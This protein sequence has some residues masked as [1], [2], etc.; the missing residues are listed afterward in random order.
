MKEPEPVVTSEPEANEHSDSSWFNLYVGCLPVGER[1]RN[2]E[3]VLLEVAERAATKHGL[4]HYKLAEYG[5]GSAYLVEAFKEYIDEEPLDGS[6]YVDSKSRLFQ[7]L[8]DELTA[9]AVRVVR[10]TF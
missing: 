8:Q 3:T 4:A 6:F 10:A 5:K 1:V 9:R 2:L 7:E